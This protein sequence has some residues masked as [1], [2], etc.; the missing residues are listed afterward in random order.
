MGFPILVRWH[1]Y[2]KSGTWLSLQW[3]HDNRDCVPNHQPHD[4]LFNRLFRCTSKKTSKLR[5]T[6]H[7]EGNSPVTAEFPAQ[8][9]SN[10]ENVSISW[11]HHDNCISPWHRFNLDRAAV[12]FLQQRLPSLLSVNMSPRKSNEVYS[13]PPPYICPYPQEVVCD[14]SNP[15]RTPDGTCNNQRNPL[16]GSSFQPLNRFLRPD[17]ADGKGHC[18]QR[19]ARFHG[20]SSA[21]SKK[22]L[23][24]KTNSSSL[25]VK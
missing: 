15:Y 12:G 18:Q 4:C 16:W 6:G 5:V 23:K 11:R 3:R 7:C 20:I 1:L 9:V 14:S 21:M 13:V 19:P 22:C 8:R 24:A 2:I 17:Y 25:L 10:A